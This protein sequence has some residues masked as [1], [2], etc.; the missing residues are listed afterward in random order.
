MKYKMHVVNVIV[1][2]INVTQG[3]RDANSSV[4]TIVVVLDTQARCFGS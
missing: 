3:R 1:K 4:K 2:I